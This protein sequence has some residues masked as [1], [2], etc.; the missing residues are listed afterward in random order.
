[1]RD[2]AGALKWVP[3]QRIEELA[4]NLEIYRDS[5]KPRGLLGRR[6]LGFGGRNRSRVFSRQR[7][8]VGL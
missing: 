6:R 7:W 1:M 4:F 2:V 8:R 3:F 5:A